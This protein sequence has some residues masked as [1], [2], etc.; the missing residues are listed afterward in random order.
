M[1]RTDAVRRMAEDYLEAVA[2]AMAMRPEAER[3]EVLAQLSE[4]LDEAVRA[5]RPA[6]G[7]SPEEAMGRIIGEMDPP[8]SFVVVEE[9]GGDAHG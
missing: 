2:A 8:E 5:M 4:Q 7:E 3:R 1:E 9:D 6:D